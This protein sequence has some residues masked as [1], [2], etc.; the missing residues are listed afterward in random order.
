M[1]YLA[2]KMA[3]ELPLLFVQALVQTLC[4]YFL[5]G[6]QGNFG[7]L[8]TAWWAL[9]LASNSVAIAVGCTVT[10]VKDAA[11]LTPLVFVPQLL[12]SGFFVSISSI[13]VWLRW[14]QWLCSL[15]YTLN[16]L[17]L[18]EFSPDVCSE[19]SETES[20]CNSLFARN[21]IS[22]DLIWFY[23]LVLFGLFLG[24]RLLGGFLLVKRARTV[25]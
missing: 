2:S 16:L 20:N 15:K 7:L 23:V 1:P 5:I 10:N 25:F 11:E 8:V 12:F 21:D 14:A 17:L 4:V 22:S 19:N 9:G 3:V 24:F 6:F 18:I 13:P